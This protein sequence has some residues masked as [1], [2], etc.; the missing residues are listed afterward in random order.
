MQ[1]KMIAQR[2]T[3]HRRLLVGATGALLLIV[4]FLGTI[5]VRAQS[6]AKAPA[7]AFDVASVRQNKSGAKPE[8][9]FPLGP[10]DM[11]TRTGGV[12]SASDQPLSTYLAFAYKLTISQTE[13]VRQHLPGWVLT[14]RFDIQA[15]TQ[16]ADPTKDQ[17]RLMMRSLLAD[18]FQLKVH[19]ETRQ[20]PVF[21]LLLAKPGKM[22]PKL[23]AHAAA[24]ASCSGGQAC[25]GL[26]LRPA[27]TPGDLHV[28]AREVSMDF[29]ARSLTG[30]GALDR[31]VLDQTGLN[32]TYDFEVEYARDSFGASSTQAASS[33]GANFA[34]GASGSAS[35]PTFLEALKEQLGLKLVAQ[36]GPVDVVIVDAV[37]RPSE[38]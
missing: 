20:L 17:M 7:L 35:G 9:N 36:K 16:I 6:P 32:G 25:G 11:Y 5:A 1:A 12:F 15:R 2:R 33:E 27:G 13:I 4:P 3:D 24:D 8:S 14:D 28:A 22:G 31:P 23:T 37:T 29:L 34:P 19:N 30:M 38:N 18:R 10:G 21:G 26:S